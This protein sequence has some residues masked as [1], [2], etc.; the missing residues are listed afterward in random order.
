MKILTL[1]LKK[2]YFEQIKNK[3]KTEEYRIV[4][5]YWEKRLIGVNYDKLIIKMGY[6]SSIE[7][8]KII[9][10]PWHGYEKKQITHAEFGDSPVWVFA[11]KLMS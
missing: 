9:E 1:N 2:I 10:L 4:K 6:P 8:E 11:I 5:P 7:K 3:T